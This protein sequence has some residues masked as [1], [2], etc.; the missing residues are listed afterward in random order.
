MIRKAARRAGRMSR[1]AGSF[2]LRF[3]L[4]AVLLLYLFHKVDVPHMMAVVADAR[5][6]FLAAAF[7][8]FVGLVGIMLGRWMIF[9]RALGLKTSWRTAARYYLIGLFGNLFL[10]SA[11][12]GDVIK[13]IGLCRSNAQKPKVVASVLLDRLSGFGGMAVVAALAV[14]YGLAQGLEIDGPLMG[15]VG[16]MAAVC[17]GIGA[18]LFHKPGYLFCCRIFAPFPRL[19][20]AVQDMHDDIALL[21]GRRDAVYRAVGISALC[22]VVFAWV[23]FL[24][25]RGLHQSV[26]FPYFLVFVPLICVAASFPSVGGLG[27]RETGTAYLLG[28]VGVEAGVAVGISLINFGFM[29][30]V[31]L[32]GGLVYLFSRT[33]EVRRAVGSAAEA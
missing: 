22:Q 15:L 21:K 27:V 19:R 33:P 17:V 6:G 20:R 25:A 13:A 24:I 14:L 28:K 5:A 11:I 12:G 7:G 30:I 1:E 26:P 23:F 9:I 29:V 16:V 4:S 2:F 8:I 18:I 3:G 10:P 32:F 31:G